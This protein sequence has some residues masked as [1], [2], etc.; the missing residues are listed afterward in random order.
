MMVT[1]TAATAASSPPIFPVANVSVSVSN[2]LRRTVLGSVPGSLTCKCSR[3]ERSEASD[4]V[5]QLA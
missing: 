4:A 1:A 5:H 2:G 3:V